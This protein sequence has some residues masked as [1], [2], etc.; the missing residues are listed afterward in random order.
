VIDGVILKP[1]KVIPDERGFLME[2]LRKDDPVFKEFGQACLPV[3]YPAVVKGGEA[4]ASLA[5]QGDVWDT[6]WDMF[7]CLCGAATSLLLLSRWH[8]RQ[9]G[10]QVLIGK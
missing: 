1:L 4:E 3:V 7:L 9:L 10:P 5:I 8:N 2:I 6:K